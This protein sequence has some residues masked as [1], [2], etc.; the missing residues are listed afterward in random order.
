[1]GNI[2]GQQPTQ[3]SEVPGIRN[4]CHANVNAAQIRLSLTYKIK[5]YEKTIENKAQ[6]LD[7]S[8]QSGSLNILSATFHAEQENTKELTMSSKE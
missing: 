1:M 7:R 5:V 3:L 2:S 8:F 6:Q 4:V